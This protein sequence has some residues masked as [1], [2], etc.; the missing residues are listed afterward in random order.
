MRVRI[1]QDEH[2]FFIVLPPGMEFGEDVELDIER[3]GDMIRIRS[4]QSN[5][6][7]TDEAP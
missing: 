1:Q 6:S 3:I 5:A 4:S 2:G 7:S